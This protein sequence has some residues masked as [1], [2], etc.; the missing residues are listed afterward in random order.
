MAIVQKI[1][2]HA[3]FEYFAGFLQSIVHQ[4]N[5]NASITQSGDII[6]LSI[7]ESDQEAIEK[8]SKLTQKYLPHSIFF[9]GV[10]T[11]QSSQSVTP[12]E[13]TS[14]NYAIA[15]CPKCLEMLTDPASSEYLNDALICTHYANEG[16]F[17]EDNTNFS[18]HYTQ[19]DTL[20]VA[21]ATKLDTLFYMTDS[22]KK[23]LFSIE[24]P[25]IKVTIA[26][27][28]LIAQTK[29]HYIEIKSAPTVKS[30]IVALNAKESGIPYLFFN[31]SYGLKARVIKDD[32]LL[33]RADALESLQT[34][35]EDSVMNRFLN[36][37]QES[38]FDEAVGGYFGCDCKFEFLTDG[39]K[40]P[41]KKVIVF[42][43][44][45]ANS[46]VATMRE[47]GIR[48]VL[49]NNYKDK[50]ESSYERFVNLETQNLFEAI[51]AILDMK[52]GYE[53]VSEKAL[54]YRGNGGVKLDTKL[55]SG[56][57]DTM[58]FL[59]SVIS[60]KLAGTSTAHIAYSV[61]ESL[62]DLGISVM[63]QL[64]QK[65]E[66]EHFILYGG[67]FENSVFYSRIKSKFAMNNPYFAK[68]IGLS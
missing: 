27:E 11:V 53:Q 51:A 30:T 42:E 52:G 57:L 31:D 21:D 40:F 64:K 65:T 48:N 26:D 8:F 33:I 24:K 3:K 60:F 10:E 17:I 49:L 39:K 35:D 14:K 44:F 5:L 28:D 41:A 47:D 2:F 63:Q 54:E 12:K 1:T 46:C 13:V 34:Y 22:E 38:G 66:I 58:N 9:G 36:I 29:K 43:G 68:S 37:K 20:L 7:D 61:F 15:P 32:T 16:Q 25:S 50:F 6:E 62:A 55:V 59:A 4:S 18:P 23:A 19:G 56:G 45:D 67:M